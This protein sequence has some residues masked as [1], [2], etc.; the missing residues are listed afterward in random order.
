MVSGG[1]RGTC[2]DGLYS[3]LWKR[4][5]IPLN[6]G[7]LSSKGFVQYGCDGQPVDSKEARVIQCYCTE[8]AA[9]TKS[10]QLFLDIYPR[11]FISRRTI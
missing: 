1:I 10:T 3:G 2:I 5:L 7:D 8:Y 9:G 6:A 11:P 4:Y